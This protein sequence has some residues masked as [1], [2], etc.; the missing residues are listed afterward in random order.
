MKA[1]VCVFAVFGL[2]VVAGCGGGGSSLAE[3]QATPPTPQP[4]PPPPPSCVEPADFGCVSPDKYREERETIELGH[5]GEEDF[6]NQ[7]GLTAVRADRAYAQLELKHGAG[8]EPGDGQTVG[9]I[10]TGIDTGHPMFAGKTVAE[11]FFSDAT[12]E[13]GDEISHGTAVASVIVGRPSAAHTESVTSPRGVARGADVAMFAIRAGSGGGEYIPIVLASLNVV[14]DHWAS[15]INHV[16]SWSSGG[17]TLDFVN[18]SVGFKGIIEQYSTQDLRNNI[19]DSI[20]AL[21][22][23]GAADKTVFIW[24]AGNAH[25][26]PCNAANFT[27]NPDLCVDV[28]GNRQVATKSPEILAGLPARIA[29]LRGHVIAV[30]AVAPDTDGDGDYE[31]AP[32]SNR[33]GIAAQWCI[34]AP[35]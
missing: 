20:A 1:L 32:F 4:P 6:K 35:A 16:T 11:H 24:A 10:D 7:W 30:V 28:N 8:T 18:V 5:N 13:I 26:D 33:C 29:E 19:G 17:R 2:I 31:I 14:D 34:A 22:Q 9:I 3:L 23:A 27:G 25:E 12:D 15:R 21:A